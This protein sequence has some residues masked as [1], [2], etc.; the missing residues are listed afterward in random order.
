MAAT[1]FT[2]AGNGRDGEIL[3]IAAGSSSEISASIE[4]T[5]NYEVC[6][7][8]SANDVAAATESACTSHDRQHLALD[9]LLR[10]RRQQQQGRDNRRRGPA[11]ARRCGPARPPPGS[12]CP[13]R[14]G[15]A[16]CPTASRS[17]KTAAQPGSCCSRRIRGDRLHPHRHSRGGHATLP[18]PRRGPAEG[19]RSLPFARASAVAG[20]S[21]AR[22]RPSRARRNR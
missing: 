14:P 19:N 10:L 12:A 21:E 17:R 18:G 16:Q 13:G 5:E 15:P 4:N 22:K 6:I 3:T 20:R 11:P 1:E 2:Q 9:E 8:S 7:D